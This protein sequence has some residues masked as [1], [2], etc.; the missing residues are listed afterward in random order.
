M[1]D[2]SNFN[3]V[4]MARVFAGQG[5]YD[6]AAGI[7]QKLIEKDPERNDLIEAL[8]ELEKIRAEKEKELKKTL[9][10]LFCEWFDLALSNNRIELLNKLK[11][12]R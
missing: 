11:K 4:T 9:I 5:L 2:D 1:A 12:R 8:S 10:P 7:Y 3:T 6:K